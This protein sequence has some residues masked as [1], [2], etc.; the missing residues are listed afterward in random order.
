MIKTE[1]ANQRFLNCKLW[2]HYFEK[3][4]L[5]EFLL[6]NYNGYFSGS[7]CTNT[8]RIIISKSEKNNFTNN[9]NIN[10]FF[11]ICNQSLFQAHKVIYIILLQ[12][13]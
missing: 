13:L 2:K 4:C 10:N 7:G 12:G 3:L 11:R 5:H 1:G 6:K 8:S 9:Y